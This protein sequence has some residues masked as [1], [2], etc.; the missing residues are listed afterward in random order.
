MPTPREEI[1]AVLVDTYEEYEAAGAWEAVFSDEVAVPFPAAVLGVPVAV[2]GF[3][4][5]KS[6]VLQC[7]VVRAGKEGRL[8]VEDLDDDGL[9]EEMQRL[10]R[11]YRA[12][13]EGD[14]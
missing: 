14:Y 13:Q 9:P 5:S 10:L 8:A 1:K 6:D 3:G 7:T 12:W 11:L 4:V 2:V